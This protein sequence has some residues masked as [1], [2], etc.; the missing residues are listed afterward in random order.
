MPSGDKTYIVCLRVFFATLELFYVAALENLHAGLNGVENG[1]EVG[2]KGGGLSTNVLMLLPSPSLFW[3][4][5]CCKPTHNA[6]A[7]S[8]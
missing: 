7:D 3:T 6:T 8:S 1:V 2:E 5:V 4:G